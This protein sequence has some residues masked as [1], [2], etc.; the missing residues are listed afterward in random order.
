MYPKL[1]LLDK[2]GNNEKAIAIAVMAVLATPVFLA[3]SV[4]AANAGEPDEVEAK[5]T[6]T[7]M[8]FANDVVP[9]P[10]G[11]DNK[12][13]VRTES[14]T[15]GK[16]HVEADSGKVEAKFDFTCSQGNVKIRS[17]GTP[18][19][20]TYGNGVLTVSGLEFTVFTDTSNGTIQGQDICGQIKVDTND[21]TM[22]L[23]VNRCPLIGPADARNLKG[24]VIKIEL[25]Y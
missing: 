5:G 4:G 3:A 17:V 6:V 7:H 16:W 23:R 24:D 19:A 25:K 8:K 20:V 12:L 22:E 11:D 10:A 21:G 1:W 18:S 14:I 2:G 15:T 13:P 9:G